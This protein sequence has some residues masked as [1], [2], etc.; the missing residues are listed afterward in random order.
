MSSSGDRPLLGTPPLEQGWISRS[1]RGPGGGIKGDE[2]HSPQLEEHAART[3]TQGAE[4]GPG[5]QTA[6][7]ELRKIPEDIPLRP[8]L[9]E[10]L[11]EPPELPEM[12]ADVVEP[13]TGL[14]TVEDE[15]S[16]PD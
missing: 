12:Q 15:K 2:N 7:G 4:L 13:E 10:E 6:S 11:L 14:G 5:E 1:P 3:E 8:E 9:P 16:E